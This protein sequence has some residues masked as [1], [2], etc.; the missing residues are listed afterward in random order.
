MKKLLVILVVCIIF[1]SFQKLEQELFSVP[2]LWTEPNYDF[3]T[4]QLSKDK[5]LLGRALF[6]D[7]ILSS[8]NQISCASCHA[9]Y[10]AFT[11]V[12]HQLSHGVFDSIG[13]RNAPALMNLAWHKSYMWDG[14]IR[15]LDMQSLAPI[16]HSDEMGSSIEDVV[17]RLNQSP[18]Y[19]K[20]SFDAYGDSAMTGE[21]TLKAL[22]QFMLTLVSANSKY[23]QVKRGDILFTVQEERGY[24]LFLLNCNTCHLEPLFSTFDFANNG[25]EL[26]ANL[27]DFGRMGVTK[28]D[29]DSLQFKIPSLRNIEFSYPYMHDGRFSSIAQVLDHYTE[30]IIKSETLAHALE[31]PIELSS[32]DKVDLTAFLLSLTDREF[33]FNKE[34]SY[35]RNVLLPAS[36]DK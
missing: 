1:F 9:Q 4:N 5:I 12:D 18:I 8:N 27:I 15:N 2:Q 19:T 6:Y 17:N 20:L 16:S 25:L 11:H 30:G 14:A 24:E 10:T 31:S 21:Y 29:Y 22:S 3:E 35:P 26:D 32:N 34:Y 13:N 33:L 23:D 36:K 28:N 7:P